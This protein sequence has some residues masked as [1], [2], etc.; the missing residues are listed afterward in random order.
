MRSRLLRCLFSGAAILLATSAAHAFCIETSDATIPANDVA[1]MGCAASGPGIFACDM[2]GTQ[3][4]WATHGVL[5]FEGGA[6]I[7]SWTRN[8]IRT[9]E[10]YTCKVTLAGS[11]GAAHIFSAL[12]AVPKSHKTFECR[13]VP[14][15]G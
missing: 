13:A 11:G 3:D 14:E 8:T 12:P 2:N 7:Y 1:V 5:A 9:T 15:C 6:V 10:E 4:S